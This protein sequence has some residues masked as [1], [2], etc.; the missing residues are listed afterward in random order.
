MPGTTIGPYRLERELGAGGMGT[1]W[2]AARDGERVA[3]KVVHQHLSGDPAYVA[4]FVREGDIGRRVRHANVVSTLDVGSAEVDGKI[5]HYIVME[6]VEGRTLRALLREMGRVPEELCRRLGRDI[7]QGLAAVHAAGAVHR[8]VKPDNVLVTQDHVVKL[9]D[10]GLARTL[11]GSEN[12]TQAGAF[13]G[14]FRYAAPEQLR[15]AGRAVDARADLHA[16][17][18][19]LHE[20]ATGRHPF[21]AADIPATVARILNE[22]A[23]PAGESVPQLSLFF[24]EVVLTLLAKE[25]AARFASADVVAAALGDGEEGEWWRDRATQ[26]RVETPRA[27]RR[28]VVPRETAL[29]GRDAEIAILRSSY[30]RAAGG[31][32]QVLLVEGEAGIGKS[33]L[34]DEF[35]GLLRQEGRDVEFLFGS[36][37]PGG[38]ATACGAFSSAYREHFGDDLAAIASALPETP[39]LVPAFA[40]FLRGDAPPRGS[41]PLTRESLHTVF[42]RAT[43]SIAA[44]RPAVILID[45]LHFAPEE[46]RGLFAALALAAARHKILLIGTARP[47]LDEKWVANLVRLGNASRRTLHRL[48]AADIVRLLSEAFGS[49]PL[50]EDLAGRIAEKSDGNPYFVFEI[51]R[52]LRE[53][54]FLKQRADGSWVTSKVIEEI[55]IPPTIAELIQARISDLSDDDRNLLEV[56]ACAGFE[57]DAALVGAVAGLA[58]IPLLQRLGTIE[59]RTRLVRSAGRRFVF[60][61][62]HVQEALV[63]GVSE[64]LREQYHAALADALESRSS[65]AAADPKSIAGALAVELADHLLRGGQG[66]RAARFVDAAVTHLE[67]GYLNAEAVKL[68][69]RALGAEGA[70]DDPTRF[71]CLLRKAERLE[72]LGRADDER[73]TLDAAAAI[74]EK[75]GDPAMRA[76]AHTRIGNHL[77]HVGRFDAAG[78]ELSVA[79]DITR[80]A[81]DVRGELSATGGLGNL[82]RFRGRLTEALA[83]HTR[84]LEISRSI[85]ERRAEAVA[86]VNLTSVLGTLGRLAD[87]QE[88]AKRAAV[89]FD[90]IGDRRGRA[91]A[92]GSLGFVAHGFGRLDESLEHD[93][94]YIELARA[95]GDRA[96]ESHAQGNRGNVLCSLGRFDEARRHFERQIDLARE[97]ADRRMEARGLGNL[98]SCHEASGRLGDA[99][100]LLE[101]GL[102]ID[103]EVGDRNLE[104]RNATSLAQIL[105]PLGRHEEA[106]VLLDGS[107]K[108]AREVGAPRETG[109]ALAGLGELALE[110]G[111]LDAAARLHAEALAVRRGLGQKDGVADSTEALGR[112]HAAA[113]RAVEARDHLEQAFALARPAPS[114]DAEVL[115]ACRLAALKA[116]DASAAAATLAELGPRLGVGRRMAAHRLLFEATGDRAHLDEAKRLLDFL[117]AHAP[118]ACRR[119]MLENVRLHREI[120]AAAA[121]AP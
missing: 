27:A 50:A 13:V 85:G 31:D 104:S 89:L 20:L 65:A 11:D 119:S 8:D 76:K 14:T 87:A 73:A 12:L 71:K 56:A 75:L 9:M 77:R 29:F 70:C 7:A 6:Y 105:I 46:G 34:V 108:T 60:D 17:G 115:A 74:A 106:R 111:D 83:L 44:A 114:A 42:A 15:R 57:F 39:L 5:A 88:H 86:A 58:P 32:G 93:A 78:A 49:A 98:G 121:A 100:E 18:T 38:A 91:V 97:C 63:A 3:V 116:R 84:C 96:Q 23:R 36:Y 81:G 48:A 67:N 25:P 118:P 30:E 117:V 110:A 107:L 33:R 35:V 2:L 37:P 80:A 51:L 113:G 52:G 19:V 103:R 95:A 101:R 82:E 54:L 16:L 24:E 47:G 1:V 55:R 61:H 41:E 102:A 69:D 40:A 72:I 99:L 45:D 92:A 79:L 21:E 94:R 120:A 26:V 28:V 109:Y 22:K 43:Q 90:E 62:H 59:K 68:L 64:P 10:L 66:A 53:G 112:V 4:R